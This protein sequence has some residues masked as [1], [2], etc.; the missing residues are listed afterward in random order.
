[1]ACTVAA[2]RISIALPTTTMIKGRAPAAMMITRKIQLHEEQREAV[3]V[4]ETHHR[5]SRERGVTL[6]HP[7]QAALMAATMAVVAQLGHTAP[8][9]ICRISHPTMHAPT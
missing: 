4:V 1:M 5:T 6:H 8:E 9:K 7:H 2:T 3:T